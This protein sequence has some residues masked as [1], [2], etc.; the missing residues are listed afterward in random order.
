[1]NGSNEDRN[2]AFDKNSAVESD[3]EVEGHAFGSGPMDKHDAAKGPHDA[4]RLA[5]PEDEN[6]PE[7]KAHSADAADAAKGPHDAAK[8]ARPEDDAEVEGHNIHPV[9]S[10][11]YVRSRSAEYEARGAQARMVNEAKSR[12]GGLLD[13]VLRRK[14]K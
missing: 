6:E 5:R 3:A 12:D 13:K 4:A 7:V 11:E 8:M 1:M 14:D 10:S 9:I 2:K